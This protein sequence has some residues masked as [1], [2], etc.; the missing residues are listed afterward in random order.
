MSEALQLA[1]SLALAFTTIAMEVF[2]S[3]YS[4]RQPKTSSRSARAA[5]DLIFVLGGKPGGLVLQ[6]TIRV[7]TAQSD[8]SSDTD[9][10][11]GE[12]R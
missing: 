2:S 4:R 6:L 9:M 11:F 5:G 7:V 12:Q 10:A 3:R 8:P 1:M